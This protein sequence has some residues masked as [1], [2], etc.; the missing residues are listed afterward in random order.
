MQLRAEQLEAQLARSLA[1]VYTI[2][3]DEPLLALEAADAVRRAARKAGYTE[4]EVFFAERGFDWSELRHAGASRSLF[5][6]RKILELRIPGGK[7]GTQGAETIAALC[8]DPNPETLLLVSLPRLDRA[9]QNSAWF[10]ALAAAG[11]LVDVFPVERARLPAWIGERLARQGQRAGREVLEFLADRVEGNLLAAFQEVQ[12]L[13]LLA[14]PGELALEDVREAVANV[15]RY[16]ASDASAALLAG[17]MARYARVIEGL[18]GEGEAP[19]YVLWAITED[20][21]A[22]ARI[23]QGLAGGR[24]LEALMRENRVWGPRQALVRGALNRF[25]PEA[26]ERSLLQAAAVDRA[27]KGVARREPWDEFLKLGL[28][29]A[30]GSKA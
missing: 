11:A 26:L 16:G 4:R 1:P 21:R 30:H 23:R 27:I 24:P 25:A 20:L 2:H 7:P 8:A 15:A 13:V 17:D 18:R 9:A 19:T 3:G 10:A 14:P 12:K 28:K 6:E 5:G 22:L 29:L